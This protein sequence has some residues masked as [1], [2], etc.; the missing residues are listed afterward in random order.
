[1]KVERFIKEYANFIKK[2]EN[3]NAAYI[4]KILISRENGYITILETMQALTTY[5]QEYRFIPESF[6]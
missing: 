2:Q 5:L 1:M 3:V 6:I 4:D